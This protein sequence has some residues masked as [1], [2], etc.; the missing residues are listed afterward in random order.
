MN[1]FQQLMQ[2]PLQT[3]LGM[4]SGFNIP[5]GMSN[6]NDIINYLLSSRQITQDQYNQAYN[7]YRNLNANGQLPRQ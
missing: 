5:K 1:P 2:N 3:L 6:P 4:N 7:Q